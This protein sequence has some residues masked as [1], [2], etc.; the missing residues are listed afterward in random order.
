MGIDPG[1]TRVG[2]GIIS[3]PKNLTLIDYGVIEAQG[4]NPAGLIQKIIAGLSSVV[5]KYRLDRVGIEKLYFTK[6][7]KTGIAVAQTRGAILLE[8]G[9]RGIPIKELSPSE[10]KLA[11]TGYGLADKKAVAKM[12]ARILGVEKLTGFDDA[13]DALAI[14]IAASNRPLDEN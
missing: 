12:V 1:S 10:I 13:S 7:V 5:K 14:A 11:V 9:R 4:K 3:G 6:N 8:I 2:Y